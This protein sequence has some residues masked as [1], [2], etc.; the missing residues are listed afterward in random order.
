MSK[1]PTSS[2]ISVAAY[3]RPRSL[4]ILMG[5][6]V[7]VAGISAPVRIL[8][9]ERLTVS[10]SSFG[11]DPMGTLNDAC[12]MDRQL[13]AARVIARNSN[14]TALVA[15]SVPGGWMV[16]DQVDGDIVLL[17]E[18]L[19]EETRW[20]TGT[21]LD[22]Q[23][24]NPEVLVM[25][26]TGEVA[27]IDSWAGPAVVMPGRDGSHP[28]FGNPTH[29]VAGRPNSIIYAS[30]V[31]IYELDM[32]GGSTRRLWTLEDFGMALDP[33]KGRAPTFRMRVQDDGTLYIAWRIQS[34][35]WSSE[36]GS[37]PQLKVQRCAP[38]PLLRTHL[39]APRV[40]LGTLGTV[41]VSISS[42]ADFMVLES[43]EVL[44]LG[45][46]SVGDKNHRSIELYGT[47]GSMK[48][49]WEL[50]ISR[51][52]ARFAFDDPRQLLLLRDG[53]SDR[54]LALV[55]VQGDGYPAR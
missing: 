35:I 52:S 55:A 36:G 12:K 37:V 25:M 21:G 49:A 46:L 51:A 13:L 4:G 27:A 5:A 2:L 10:G 39:D 29:A 38:K 32:D 17:D 53:T 18:Q 7:M 20:K 28:V 26:P 54:H 50:P 33:E 6:A 41:M 42:I 22:R 14:I 40:S 47:D 31:G 15:E 9:Q 3:T 43:G 30:G 16:V 1:H 23:W 11:A 8:G 44:V 19:R 34:S 24:M 45:A 48:R